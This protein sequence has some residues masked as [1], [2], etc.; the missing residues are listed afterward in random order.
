MTNELAPQRSDH[1][2]WHGLC[3][4]ALAALLIGLIPATAL[5]AGESTSGSGWT[6]GE[7]T[8]TP[9]SGATPVQQG[10]SLG[11]GAGSQPTGSTTEAPASTATP[12][13][14]EPTAPS[15]TESGSSEYS[16]ASAAPVTEVESTPA[17]VAPTPVEKPAAA[18]AANARADVGAG[19][20]IARPA[21]PPAAA[22]DTAPAASPAP[23]ASPSEEAPD[24]SGVP[25]WLLALGAILVLAWV[26]RAIVVAYRRRR[27]ARPTPDPDWRPEAGEW[28]AVLEQIQRER[29]VGG[30]VRPLREVGAEP[31]YGVAVVDEDGR[32][33]G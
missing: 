22:A 2:R 12:E 29:S 25:L 32:V 19:V 7:G 9:E 18:R 33:A 14:V 5:A 21:S 15:Y 8:S 6:P 31:D 28:D 23:V 4:A 16:E 24:S 27:S 10:S 13:Y 26:G 11:S 20:P 1:R 17:A 30:K 3:V